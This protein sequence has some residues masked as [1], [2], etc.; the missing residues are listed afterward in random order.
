[1]KSRSFVCPQCGQKISFKYALTIVDGKRYVC[2]KC[3]T[4]LIPQTTNVIYRRFT[5]IIIAL[6]FA[7]ASSSYVFN[8]LKL[9]RTLL[10][11]SALFVAI[12]GVYLLSIYL[13]VVRTVKMKPIEG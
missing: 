5:A 6:A 12:V 4:H 11:Q 9:E 13:L 3:Q 2:N 8:M 1:M 10:Y 7:I